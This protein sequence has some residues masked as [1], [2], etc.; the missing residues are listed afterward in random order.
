MMSV[1][2]MV[3]SLLVAKLGGDPA[4][5]VATTCVILGV[6]AFLLLL[7]VSDYRVTI[8]SG[9]HV[10]LARW[11]PWRIMMAPS[12]FGPLSNG[13]QSRA[14]Y[15]SRGIHYAIVK[16]GGQNRDDDDRSCKL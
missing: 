11:Y 7:S 2:S 9:Y 6:N 16:K 3:L 8:D 12:N 4:H 5:S 1:K 10:W 15:H 14:R 13:G